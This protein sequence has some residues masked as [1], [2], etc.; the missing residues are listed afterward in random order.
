MI[1][2]DVKLSKQIAPLE[3][4]VSSLLNLRDE[5]DKSSCVDAREIYFKINS[6]LFSRYPH[7]HHKNKN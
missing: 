5:L 3:L 1:D 2:K 7:E 4:M 6:C